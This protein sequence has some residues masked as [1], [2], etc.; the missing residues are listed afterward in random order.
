MEVRAGYDEGLMRGG[1]RLSLTGKP[2]LQI[3]AWMAQTKDRP[4]P[5]GGA[6]ISCGTARNTAYHRQLVPVFACLI[7]ALQCFAPLG[8]ASPTPESGTVRMP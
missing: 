1:S 4:A 3:P 8:P 2:A 5:L 7:R 6:G